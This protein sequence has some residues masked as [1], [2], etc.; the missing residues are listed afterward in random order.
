MLAYLLALAIML[1]CCNRDNYISLAIK[2]KNIKVTIKDM[3]SGLLTAVLTACY[4]AGSNAMSQS[5][6]L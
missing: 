4:V 1:H 3:L 2:L 6:T 5:Q